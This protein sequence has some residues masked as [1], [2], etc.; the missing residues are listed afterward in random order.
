MTLKA[1]RLVK[2]KHE[3][4][5]FTGMG[6]AKGGGRWNSMGIGAVYTSQSLA[7]AALETLVH[8]FPDTVFIFSFFEIHF[9]AN[10]VETVP[11][12][13]LP[14]EWRVAEPPY[15]GTRSIGNDWLKKSHSPVLRVPSAIIP[16]DFN[17]LLNP[18]HPDFHKIRIGEPQP[19]AFDP[20]LL[21][22]KL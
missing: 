14:E 21:R 11:E 5:A 6:S 1:F 4:T 22:R 2:K 18:D 3:D 17:Y 13:R 9:D 20:R 19:F 16:I 12:E 10:M 15:R 7:L 8:L